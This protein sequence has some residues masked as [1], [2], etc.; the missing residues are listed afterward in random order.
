VFAGSRLRLFEDGDEPAAF[1]NLYEKLMW[2]RIPMDSPLNG[3]TLFDSN[4]AEFFDLL[5]LSIVREGQVILAPSPQFELQ[6]GDLLVVEG[7]PDELAIVRGLQGLE[8]KQN[9]TM[10]QV[11]LESERVGLIEAVLAP[12]SNLVDKSLREL[13]FR[14]KYD[15]SVLAI[16]RNGRAYRSDLGDMPLKFGD[17]FLIYGPREKISLLV[18]ETDFIVLSEELQEPPRRAKA[19]L[20]IMIM[21]GV[22]GVVLAGWLSIAIA[23]VAGAVLMVISG[24]LQMDEAYSSIEWRAVFLIA[25]MLPLGIAMEQSGAAQ[26]LAEG[27]INLVGDK[28]STALLAGFFIMTSIALQ[29]MPNA[30][31][32]VIMA[33]IAINTAVDLNLS[34]Y[35]LMMVIAIAA[36]AAFMSPVGHPANVLVMGPGGYR[37]SDY[38]KAGIPLTLVVLIVTLIVVPIFWPL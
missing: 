1:Y 32:A 20:A 14:E 26:F 4:L 17:G 27:M 16:W 9:I 38:L 13:H 21:V 37:F 33:P 35:A 25:G 31:V 30:V 11:E 28:G 12:R 15:L 7:R 34:P 5:A 24:C 18:D 3:R 6:E 2:V 10:E 8:I 23:A 29:F 19:P 36:S 22:I